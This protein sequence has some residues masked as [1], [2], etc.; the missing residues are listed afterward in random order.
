MLVEWDSGWNY[1]LTAS[2]PLFDG[3]AREGGVNFAKGPCK[4]IAD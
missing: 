3:F 2:L 4:T 1:G